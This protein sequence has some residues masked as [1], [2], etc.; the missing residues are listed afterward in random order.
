MAL[1]KSSNPALSKDTFNSVIGADSDNVMTIN[2]TVN[3]V[4][5]LS[6][7]VFFAAYYTVTAPRMI[8]H[9]SFTDNYSIV[10][11]ADSMFFSFFTSTQSKG[12]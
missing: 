1:F 10:C 4:Y 12:V 3:K 7:I 9:I 2:G 5:I 6:T 8:V 11:S